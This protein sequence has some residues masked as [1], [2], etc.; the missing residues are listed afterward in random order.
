ME[1]ALEEAI[2]ACN[3]EQEEQPGSAEMEDDRPCA[4]AGRRQEEQP[5]R[6]CADEGQEEQTASAD[7]GA[8]AAYGEQEEQPVS[9]GM[10]ADRP[11]AGVDAD[12]PHAG[13]RQEEQPG[14]PC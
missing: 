4:P 3:G 10:D 13:V 12:G 9:S 1:I 2:G 14:R 8:D 6:T 11:H 5:D 7:G